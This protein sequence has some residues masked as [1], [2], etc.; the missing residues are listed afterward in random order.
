MRPLNKIILHCS[1]TEEG[2]PYS[3]EDI[4]IWHTRDRRWT[5]IGY[6]YVIELNGAIKIGRPLDI[7]GAH[8]RNHNVG[9][10]GVCYVGGL[11]DNKPVDTMTMQQEVSWL[12]LVNSLRTCFGYMPVHGHN[13]YSNKACP[14][15]DVQVKYGFLNK[16]I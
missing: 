4:R 16:E 13:E 15:F 6:H 7:V 3:C 14:S 8:V 11:R 10:I 1:A 5:D 9:S 12:S 2:K